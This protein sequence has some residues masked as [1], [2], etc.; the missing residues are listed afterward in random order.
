MNFAVEQ[1][2]QLKTDG[3]HITAML[4]YAD[5]F[6]LG[7]Y[8]AVEYCG[9]PSIIFKMGRKDG[10]EHEAQPSGNLP[11][12]HHKVSI[13]DRMLRTGLSRKEFVAIMGSHTIGFAK[14]ENTGLKGRWT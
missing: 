7:G 14:M 6:Q 8:A 11:D 5:L 9:G 2:E 13:L 1:I 4:S 12:A 3:N 10:L